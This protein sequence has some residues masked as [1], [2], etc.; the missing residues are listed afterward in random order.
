MNNN[1]HTLLKLLSLALVICG[2]CLATNAQTR[3]PAQLQIESLEPLAAKAN[4][5]VDVSL[6]ERL[7][8][9][10]PAGLIHSTDPDAK[11]LKEIV[12]G[13]KGVYVRNFQFNDE[14]EYSEADIAAIR[15]QLRA[16]G[17]VRFVNVINKRE[18]KN[19]EV[20]LMTGATGASVEGLAILAAE[21]KELTVVNIIGIIDIDKLSKLEGQF[22]IPDLGIEPDDADKPDAKKPERPAPAA[23]TKKP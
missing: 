16:P 4:E 20:Y 3:Y 15:T 19:V 18:H 12:L 8:R 11:N 21:P 9:L 22:G 23:V 7:L 1:K 14:G 6:D 5:I 13:L 2:A 10:I 17:W